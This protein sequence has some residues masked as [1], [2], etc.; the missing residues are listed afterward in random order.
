MVTIS[1]CLCV[2]PLPGVSRSSI[3]ANMVPRN[4]TNTIRILVMP[5]DR[6]RDDIG[7]IAADLA[8]RRRAFEPKPSGPSTV[9]VTVVVR[10][11]SRLKPS[12]KKRMNGPTAHDALLSFALREKQRRPPFDV[13][14]VDVVAERRADDLAGRCHGEHDLRLRIVPARFGIEV[15]HPRR[16]RPTTSAGTLVKISASGPMP[17]SRYWLHQPCLIST[18]LSRIAS[19]EPGFS[20]AR[21]SPIRLVDL[22]ADRGRGVEI[23]ARALLDDAFEQSRSRR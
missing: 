18:S 5:V 20:F 4:S 17:T 12:S 11:S 14:Q 6:L 10:T 15:P 22:Y 23:A 21:S 8:D 7:R 19:G 13:A 1:P 16:S 2:N 9:S 3:G